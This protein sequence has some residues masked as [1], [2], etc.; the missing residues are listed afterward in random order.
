MKKKLIVLSALLVVAALI[1]WF[2]YPLRSYVVMGVYSGRHSRESVMKRQGFSV[3]IPAGQGWY[4]FMLTYN[5]EGFARWSGVD[6]DMS[7]LYSFGAFDAATRTS[8]IYDAGSDRYCAFY[9]A[10]V[11]HMDG[12]VFGFTD[13]GEVDMDEVT[14]AVKYDY[15]QLVIAG[16]GCDSPVLRVEGFDLQTGLT[17]AESGGWTRIDAVIAANG[18][19]HNYKESKTAYLQYGPP[20]KAV[21]ESFA[22]IALQGRLYIKY[23]EEY[24][25]TVMLYAIAR[26]SATVDRCDADLLAET[27][28]TD[29]QQ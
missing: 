7:I 8:S 13:S 3:D 17:C 14:L 25:C 26:D 18:V 16:F 22:V 2:F 9:G 1:F 5:A 19:A 12:G 20:M 4:P 23:F 27:A 24:D 29:L 11:A 21:D 28:I 6:A 10:Y 15:T